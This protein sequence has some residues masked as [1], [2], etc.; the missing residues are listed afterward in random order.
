MAKQMRGFTLIEIM[1]VVAIVAILMAVAIPSYRDY[2]QRG[3]I[4][5]ATNNLSNFQA[6]M[7]QFYQDNRT[8]STTSAF[9]SPCDPTNGTVYAYKSADW[10]FTCSN[11]TS[12]TYQVNAAGKTGLTNGFAYYVN[13]AGNQATTSVPASWQGNTVTPQNCFLTKKGQTC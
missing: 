12:L 10:T 4:P 8:Y 1:I 9:T 13:Q 5:T 6:A 11:F 7:E 2:V 3:K